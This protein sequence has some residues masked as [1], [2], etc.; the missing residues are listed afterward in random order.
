MLSD[1][2]QEINDKLENICKAGLKKNQ[3][4][5]IGKKNSITKNVVDVLNNKLDTSEER[6]SKLEDRSR[7]ITQCGAQKEK[8][9]ENLCQPNGE[10]WSE[11]CLLEE[12]HMGRN[13]Q[14][15]V[16]PPAQSL[17]R[18]YPKKS[19]S[20]VQK[21]RR[22][23]RSQRQELSANHTPHRWAEPLLFLPQTS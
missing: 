11:D 16:P 17:A 22:T 2:F 7:Q 19:M 3:P 14:A 20:L 21:L 1:K 13:G 9:V 6:I 4:E 23:R 5:L 8:K 18:G 15:R 10:F 12:P